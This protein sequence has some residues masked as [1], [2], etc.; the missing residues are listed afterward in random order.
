VPAH[1]RDGVRHRTEVP[2]SAHSGIIGR[3]IEERG[4]AVP[5]PLMFAEN[6][7]RTR[8]APSRPRS[9][10]R[11]AEDLELDVHFTV[12]NDFVTPS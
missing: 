11:G 8:T 7:E 5:P 3:A 2:G 10:E 9:S 6:A 12:S 4:R 1:G